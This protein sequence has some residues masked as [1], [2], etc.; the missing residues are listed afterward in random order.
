[1]ETM[2]SRDYGHV[3]TRVYLVHHGLTDSPR[4][5]HEM[6]ALHPRRYPP[7]EHILAVMVPLDALEGRPVQPCTG[8]QAWFPVLIF[9]ARVL[10][11]A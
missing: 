4:S 7:G 2:R 6:Q 11:E 1:M 8:D 10:R 5:V 3:S 9:V